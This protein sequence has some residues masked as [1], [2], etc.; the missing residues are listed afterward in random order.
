MCHKRLLSYTNLRALAPCFKFCVL[1]SVSRAS[2]PKFERLFQCRSTRVNSCA[3]SDYFAL[4]STRVSPGFL[5]SACFSLLLE[6][7]WLFSRRVARVSPCVWEHSRPFD[8]SQIFLFPRALYA[9][10]ILRGSPRE[11]SITF[12][13]RILFASCPGDQRHEDMEGLLH[14]W[15]RNFRMPSV[16]FPLSA[17]SFL[18]SFLF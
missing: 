15:V 4:V 11:C 16:R 12:S 9:C 6:V 13:T 14:S 2:H 3:T 17:S 7:L 8:L 18:L 5:E 10:F 1:T